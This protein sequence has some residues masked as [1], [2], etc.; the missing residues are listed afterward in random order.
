MWLGNADELIKDG[1][2]T[3]AN[4]IGTR[5]KIMTDLINYGMDS[6]SAFQIMEKVRKG[7]GVS[8]EYQAEM[9][10]AGVPEWYIDSCL[11]IKY[12]F[13]EPTP[14]RMF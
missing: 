1:T 2:A 11:K 3:I 5:D 10:A 13:P 4:V 9:R 7:K 12:M 6:E 14:R 8:D